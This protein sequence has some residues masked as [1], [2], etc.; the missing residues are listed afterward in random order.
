MLYVEFTTDL[1]A[2]VTVEAKNP[3]EI[4]ELQ[5]RYGKSMGWHSGDVPNGGYQF[6]LEN[7][8]DF[9]WAL[10]GGRTFKND[11]GEQCVWCR[12]YV[13]KRRELEA[14]NTKKMKMPKA[15]KYSRGARP[16]DPDHIREKADGDIEYVSLAIF[17]GNGRRER[18]ALAKKE[19]VLQ[20]A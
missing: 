13:Y 1:G 18:Y 20:P 12:G 15:V 5:R 11:E 10:V 17:R 9:D 7:E 4:L 14:V 16:T 6:P 3:D 2:K 19:S 8:H